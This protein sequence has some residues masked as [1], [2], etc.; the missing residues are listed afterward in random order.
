MFL[1]TDPFF[2]PK[3]PLFLKNYH[4]TPLPCAA[5][6]QHVPLGEGSW[7]GSAKRNGDEVMEKGKQTMSRV[8]GSAAS[9]E[10]GRKKGICGFPAWGSP[11]DGERV[12]HSALWSESFCPNK[13]ILE[14]KTTK[15]TNK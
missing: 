14:K 13:F 2:V 10:E 8:W 1:A 3:K 6:V 7:G 12:G 9:E 15:Q 4:P 11:G 5:S